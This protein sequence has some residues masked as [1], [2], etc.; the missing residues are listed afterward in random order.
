MDPLSTAKLIA[1]A[2]RIA[3]ALEKLCELVEENGAELET[4]NEIFP[5][6][7]PEGRTRHGP[8]TPVPDLSRF[9]ILGGGEENEADH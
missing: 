2:D 1:A 9:P 5:A 8:N 6:L 7:I 4:M 3:A